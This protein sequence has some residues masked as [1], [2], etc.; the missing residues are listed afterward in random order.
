MSMNI[1]ISGEREVYFLVGENTRTEIQTV[2]FEALQTPTKVTYSI[3]DAT[4]KELSYREYVK[5]LDNG[6]VV[7]G[8]DVEI[9]NGVATVVFEGYT[10]N[11]ITDHLN[12]FDSWLEEMKARGFTVKFSIC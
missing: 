5:T 4:D 2:S 8:D 3:M 7:V 1:Y 11:S 10:Y 6:D 9:I 12:S